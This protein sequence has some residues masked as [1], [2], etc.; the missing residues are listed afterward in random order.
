MEPKS[1]GARIQA[2]IQSVLPL[3]S[4][5]SDTVPAEGFRTNKGLFLLPRTAWPGDWGGRRKVISSKVEGSLLAVGSRVSLF[6]SL[7]FLL[8][9]AL[10]SG[11]VVGYPLH[12]DFTVLGRSMLLVQKPIRMSPEQGRQVGALQ[13]S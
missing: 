4:C 13:T 9:G 2:G 6:Y 5:L 7:L 11:Q 3:L 8:G 1:S 12:S 10:D